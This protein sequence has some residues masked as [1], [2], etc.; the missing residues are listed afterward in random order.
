MQGKTCTAHCSEG[1]TI[2]AKGYVTDKYR[3]DRGAHVIDVTCWC[4]TL[5]DRIISVIGGVR[6]IAFQVRLASS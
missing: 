2:I 3:N 4:E 1:D 6:P 5:D